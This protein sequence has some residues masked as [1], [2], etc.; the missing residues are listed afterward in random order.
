MLMEGEVVLEAVAPTVVD[1]GVGGV[2]SLLLA[3]AGGGV[4]G[5]KGGGGNTVA[6][7]LKSSEC[8]ATTE[9]DTAGDALA[10]VADSIIVAAGID[11]VGVGDA[12]GECEA[13]L[14]N[15]CW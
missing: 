15:C 8:D 4:A 12:E 5:L 9:V 6:V 10:S 2:V 13:L 1:A 7:G 14:V 3:W 11:T